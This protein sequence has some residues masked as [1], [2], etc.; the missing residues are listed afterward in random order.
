MSKIRNKGICVFLAVLFSSLKLI[1]L[2][3]NSRTFVPHQTKLYV[4]VLGD[5]ADKTHQDQEKKAAEN[6]H[7]H[8]T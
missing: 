4:K 8:P 2:K 1:E 7:N 3:T 5:L 6:S